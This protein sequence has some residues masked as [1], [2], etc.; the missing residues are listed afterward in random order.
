MSESIA[1]VFIAA[2]ILVALAL[3][4][5]CMESLAGLMRRRIQKQNFT[6]EQKSDQDYERNN[7]V[8]R[9]ESLLNGG[10]SS[11]LLP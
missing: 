11:T 4:V 2:G 5:P 6:P 1:S 9:I 3:F 7:C 10:P 8:K